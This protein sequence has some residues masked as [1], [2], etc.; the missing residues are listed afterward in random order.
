MEKYKIPI[1]KKVIEIE[2]N[3]I[4]FKHIKFIF[5][6]RPREFFKYAEYDLKIKEKQNGRRSL[7]N[8]LTNSK[9]A[10]DSQLDL[11]LYCY[12]LYR[13]S[14]RK[15]WK[16]PQ[17]IKILKKI[18]ISVPDLII[19]VTNWRNDLEHRYKLP[20]KENV[21]ESLDIAKLFLD[22]T[23][24]YTSPIIT[25]VLGTFDT[26]KIVISFDYDKEKI[27][28][29]M[30]NEFVGEISSSNLKEYLK[31]LKLFAE[32]GKEIKMEK[33]KNIREIVT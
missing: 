30:N 3:K 26:K 11:L 23:E 17:K 4:N 1:E 9:R 33:Q 6:I 20:T 29:R 31:Y 13:L 18:N 28:I 19:K 8:S 32:L 24:I 5:E 12:G 22:S 10:I 14:N 25:E 16:V 15:E 2:I 7:I 27:H 21:R